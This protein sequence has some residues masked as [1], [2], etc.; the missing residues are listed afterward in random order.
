MRPTTKH[1]DAGPV[2]AITWDLW[3]N[4]E[5]DRA[6]ERFPCKGLH[7]QKPKRDALCLTVHVR[8][9]VKREVLEEQQSIVDHRIGELMDLERW[10]VAVI[11][12]I[13]PVVPRD[14]VFSPDT[15]KIG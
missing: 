1:T 7:R 15:P 14:I 8:W 10:V 6:I 5:V 2:R 4:K 12:E 9:I 3:R 13:S 11:K